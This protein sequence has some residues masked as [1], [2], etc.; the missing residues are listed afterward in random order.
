MRARPSMSSPLSLWLLLA[1]APGCVILSKDDIAARKDLDADGVSLE[2]DCDDNDPAVGLPKTYTLDGDGDGFAGDEVVEACAR[3]AGAA[4]LIGD[5]DD[6]NPLVFPGAPDAPYDGL[7]ADCLG[8]DA[9]GDGVLDDFDQDGDGEAASPEGADCDDGDPAVNSAAPE[10]CDGVDNDCDA[11]IDADDPDLDPAD[12]LIVYP[13]EDGDG[14]GVD[15]LAEAVCSPVAG[16]ALEGGDCDDGAAA[17]NPGATEL[18]NLGV[19]DDCDGLVDAADP[20][21]D[22]TSAPDWYTDADRDGYGVGAS[23]GAACEAPVEGAAPRDGDCDDGLP[24]VNPGVVEVCDGADN[25][26][27]SLVDDADPSLDPDSQSRFYADVDADGYG[28]AAT[29]V[30]ACTQPA[31]TVAFDGD[32][33]DRNPDV[34]PGRRE[35]CNGGVDDDCD[36]VADDLDASLDPRSRLSF[37][38][39]ADGDGYGDVLS[40]W[41]A[42]V[43]PAGTVSDFSDCDDSDGSVNPAADVEACDDGFDQNCDGL[44]EVCRTAALP[45]PADGGL[46]E[47]QGV[48]TRFFDSAGD[49]CGAHIALAMGDQA[50]CYVDP[51]GDLRCAGRIY[52]QTFG[53]SFVPAGLSDVSQVLIAATQTGVPDGNAAVAISAGVVQSMGHDN[54]FGQLG[55]GDTLPRPSWTPWAGGP[56]IVEHI[57]VGDGDVY[58]GQ[59][60]GSGVYCV[61][62]GYGWGPVI[63]RTTSSAL[64][65][66]PGGSTDFSLT[67]RWRMAQGEAGCAVTPNGL[68]CG[69]TWLGVPGEVVD[70]GELR[71]DG[72]AVRRYAWL[73]AS[74]EVY[75]VDRFSTL[76]TTTTQR[77]AAQPV[78]AIAYHPGVAS[79]CG[80]YADGSL[81]C[82]GENPQG[83][84]GSGGYAALTTE[85]VVLPP[86]SIDTTCD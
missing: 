74:G 3:P 51:V 82:W 40:G 4:E 20:D 14:F 34:S 15:A 85:Q 65:V 79:L 86:G 5:C 7:D 10:L 67:T 54:T 63:V 66:E 68:E 41:A 25:D 36:G 19:D 22:E 80:V 48:F 17:V 69:P 77:F 61:G 60:P 26:C 84:L 30:R 6:S 73:N 71:P 28:D 49:R 12:Y 18:C 81:V 39:D 38:A 64:I 50:L 46:F 1:A 52:T 47:Y 62:D 56:A 53:P 32:C 70:G 55:T 2:D 21:V 45:R 76:S 13:D 24:G 75:V 37:Y 29:E 31:A 58:C 9:D 16:F 33:D 44:I 83:M 27:D 57:A 72:G 35:V 43:A 59:D 78:L 23:L 42:C 8:E 11:L